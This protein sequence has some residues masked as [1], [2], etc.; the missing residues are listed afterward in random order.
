MQPV[1][2][3][4]LKWNDPFQKYIS[5]MIPGRHVHELFRYYALEFDIIS[6]NFSYI[7]SEITS[8]LI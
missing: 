6:N 1:L 8:F 5:L 4:L 7:K 3:H 2:D